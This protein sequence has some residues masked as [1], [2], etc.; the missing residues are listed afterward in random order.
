MKRKDYLEGKV[1]HQ[2]YY[3]A[4][5]EK[6]G[7]SFTESKLLPKIRKA[8]E[9]GDYYLNSISL[10]TWDNL[11]YSYIDKN[12]AMLVFQNEFEDWWSLAGHVCALKAAARRDAQ[13]ETT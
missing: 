9:E 2:E 6:L 7:I 8:L 3:E 11:A 4:V 5:A 12:H 13:K 1:T 10:A